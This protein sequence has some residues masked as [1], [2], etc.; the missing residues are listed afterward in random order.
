M[1]FEYNR[2]AFRSAC[3]ANGI[4]LLA[5]AY[6]SCVLLELSL[7]QHLGMISVGNSVGHN[8][9]FLVHRLGLNMKYQRDCNALQAQLAALL[10]NLY[11]QGTDGNPRRIPSNSYAHLRYL[12][13]SSDWATHASS[14]GDISMLY[15]LLRRIIHLIKGSIGVSV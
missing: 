2:K 10:A 6:C 1:T 5:T 9:P 4:E 13:H 8:L 14:D 7:K 12:R 11:S 3:N 15:G